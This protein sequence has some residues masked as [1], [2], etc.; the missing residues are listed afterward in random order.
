LTQNDAL[1]PD[2]L[3]AVEIVEWQKARRKIA[4]E[5]FGRVYGRNLLPK[6]PKPK[7]PRKELVQRPVGV[8]RISRSRQNRKRWLLSLDCGHEKWISS[9][10]RP[11]RAKEFCTQGSCGDPPVGSS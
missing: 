1:F 3:D 6:K 2:D 7:K 5:L 9:D 8:L 10:G 11:Q 4:T